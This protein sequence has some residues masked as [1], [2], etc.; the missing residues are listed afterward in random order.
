MQ[1]PAVY[2]ILTHRVK[3]WGGSS[4]A[5]KIITGTFSQRKQLNNTGVGEGVGTQ[6][7]TGIG[8]AQ[9]AGDGADVHA[10]LQ[11][12]GCKGVPQIVKADRLQPQCSASSRYALKFSGFSVF[13]TRFSFL[14][15][16]TSSRGLR[17]IS[18]S[19]T[20]R[21]SAMCSMRCKLRM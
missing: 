18:C 10:A 12:R 17:R 21:S 11:R 3:S 15:K 16:I 9:H 2:R 1:L 19:F 7:E 5:Q 6:S 20:A 8:V 4:R 14:G 13:I